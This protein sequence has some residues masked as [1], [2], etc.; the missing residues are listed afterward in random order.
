[1]ESNVRDFISNFDKVSVAFEET[2]KKSAKGYLSNI[3]SDKIVDAYEKI[4]I[5]VESMLGIEKEA[6]M[7]EESVSDSEF[8][9]FCLKLSKFLAFAVFNAYLG[10]FEIDKAVS[11]DVKFGF[12]GLIDVIEAYTEANSLVVE[13]SEERVQA[14]LLSFLREGISTKDYL[15]QAL[16]RSD[17]SQIALLLTPSGTGDSNA[18][19]F[20]D[21]V[22]DICGPIND[23]FNASLETRV[24][25]IYRK[26]FAS[27]FGQR[28]YFGVLGENDGFCNAFTVKNNTVHAYL[29]YTALFTG[30]YSK[31]GCKVSNSNFAGMPYNVEQCE[32]RQFDIAT[33]LS[34]D[35]PV[36][37]P[38]KILEFTRKSKGTVSLNRGFYVDCDADDKKSFDVYANKFIFPLIEDLYK[39]TITTTLMMLGVV[40][41]E[42]VD[43]V[44]ITLSDANKMRNLALILTDSMKIMALKSSIQRI[45]RCICTM[46]LITDFRYKPCVS[47]SKNVLDN[48]PVTITKFKVK[49]VTPAGFVTPDKG[50]EIFSDFLTSGES[51]L[52]ITSES[53]ENYDIIDFTV[54]VDNSAS[55]APLFGYK[56]VR[57]LRENNKPVDKDNILLGELQDGTDY[58]SVAGGGSNNPSF[59]NELTH[60]II[61]DAGSG[62]GVMT[63]NIIASYIAAGVPIFYIDRKPDMASLFSYL[64]DDNMFLVNGGDYLEKHDTFNRW[65][66]DS[67]ALA[68]WRDYASRQVPDYV[69]EIFGWQEDISDYYSR[70]KITVGDLVYFRAT[71]LMAGIIYARN[72]F[73][74]GEK[75]EKLGGDNGIFVVVDEITNFELYFDSAFF[76]IDNPVLLPYYDEKLLGKSSRGDLD[77]QIADAEHQLRNKQIALQYA[78]EGKGQATAQSDVEHAQNTL[79][80]LKAKKDAPK[81]TMLEG[82]AKLKKHILYATQFIRKLDECGKTVEGT[83]SAGF[84]SG[85]GECRNSNI[86][87][88]GQRIQKVPYNGAYSFDKMLLADKSRFN[89]FCEDI[90][91]VKTFTALFPPD[92]IVGYNNDG[93]LSSHA[94]EMLNK[95]DRYF[96]Y[97]PSAKTASGD[98]VPAD[99]YYGVSRMQEGTPDKTVFFKP[100]LV[101]NTHYECDPNNKVK[102]TDSH[103][104]E[105]KDDPKYYFVDMLMHNVGIENWK[106]YRKDHLKNPR[107]ESWGAINEGIGFEGLINETMMANGRSGS[108][109]FKHDLS[110]SKEIADFVAS[111][112]GYKSYQEFLFDFSPKGLFS[113]EDVY[114]AVADP[115][116]YK[117]YK[118]RF[119]VYAEYDCLSYVDG[120]TDESAEGLNGII[121]D[122]MTTGFSDLADA[123]DGG[124]AETNNQ[125]TWGSS[126]FESVDEYDDSGFEDSGFG[127]DVADD[128][129]FGNF[130]NEDEDTSFEAENYNAMSDGSSFG[131]A[132]STTS[133]SNPFYNSNVNNMGSY[134]NTASQMAQTSQPLGSS[135]SSRDYQYQTC[136]DYI[137]HLRRTLPSLLVEVFSSLPD[138]VRRRLNM[139]D[140]KNRYIAERKRQIEQRFGFD[141]RNV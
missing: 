45:E 44:D 90:S 73:G 76:S 16:Y 104:G 134:Q 65:G 56:A 8:S 19:R 63:M 26:A 36:Y 103:T 46:Y 122:R 113:I 124:Y 57:L 111:C 129:G 25:P 51:D 18:T 70:G 68:F 7:V 133:S 28:K 81:K 20:A 48:S 42:E 139:E 55:D 138:D 71:L 101:L 125:T 120:V 93:L 88:I 92:F 39:E 54:I 32:S 27:N 47:R 34:S 69:K 15:L 17:M 38:F 14:F 97:V 85:E 50:S 98:K 137:N 112:F 22:L 99:G 127:D 107:D 61:G 109:D 100:Y 21:V 79:L 132:S 49:A 87:Y 60:F 91:F 2:L 41:Q 89:K 23:F 117:D 31:L 10:G 53:V 119:G 66:K 136:V 126:S 72:R 105:Q 116:W 6:V 95:K 102:Y 141:M 9:E 115:T 30:V 74:S 3:S 35:N 75:Y 106:V 67:Q 58:I 64:T 96:A 12:S 130:G 135:T 118:R 5:T 84:R 108:F 52:K 13:G 128:F 77:K 140:V 4:A 62:K 80:K 86:L 37:F 24:K 94:K 43:N 78:K 33:M 110:K 83:K 121:S 1:M 59:Q 82:Q 11:R 114:T 29:S 123:E 40:T 131:A